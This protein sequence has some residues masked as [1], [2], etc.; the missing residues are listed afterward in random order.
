M[1]VPVARD[2]DGYAR[3]DLFLP[4]YTSEHPMKY[5]ASHEK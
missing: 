5:V 4:T 3:T 2:M 1:G